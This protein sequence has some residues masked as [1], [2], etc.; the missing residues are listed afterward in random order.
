[1]PDITEK[2]AKPVRRKGKVAER[3]TPGR[4]IPA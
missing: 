3:R 2:N 1:M 4:E